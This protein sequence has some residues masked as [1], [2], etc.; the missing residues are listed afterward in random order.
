V[1]SVCIEY[2]TTSTILRLS[3]AATAFNDDYCWLYSDRLLHMLADTSTTTAGADAVAT[4][5]VT[6]VTD[7]LVLATHTCI[8]DAVA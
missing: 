8:R 7:W 5:D 1:N 4:A 3:S 2:S 6:G